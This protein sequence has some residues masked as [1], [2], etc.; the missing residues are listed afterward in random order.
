MTER[1]D[2]TRSGMRAV[3]NLHRIGTTDYLISNH[4]V[5]VIDEV[6]FVFARHP[7]SLSIERASLYFLHRS[8]R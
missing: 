6:L 5:V 4:Y 8:G 3:P 7:R 2:Q 1:S